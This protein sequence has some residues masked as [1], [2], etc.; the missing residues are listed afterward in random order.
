MLEPGQDGYLARAVP[1]NLRYANVLPVAVAVCQNSADVRAALLWAQ[2]YN[3]PL[4]VRSGGHSFAGFSTTDGLMIDVSSMNRVEFD[5]ASG[6]VRLEG[7][8]R[9]AGARDK[10]LQVDTAI[11]HG[12]CAGVGV[13]GLTLGG[14]IGFN[15]RSQGL[16]RPP[17]RRCWNPAGLK[18]L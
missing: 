9:N 18:M 12:R 1:W 17:E 5:A 11:T 13:A 8:V 2:A 15:M 6:H 4:T 7:G 14:G 3:V 10:L 16:M